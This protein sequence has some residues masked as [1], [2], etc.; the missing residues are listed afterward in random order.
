[1]IKFVIDLRQ[2]GVFHHQTN[3]PTDIKGCSL[4][5]PVAKV[6]FSTQDYIV[7]PLMCAF[8]TI[9]ISNVR[10]STKL[11][12]FGDFTGQFVIMKV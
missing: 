9:S 6:D 11:F 3:Q 10:I 5:G 2:D 4:D 1:V 12:I 7:T 8:T